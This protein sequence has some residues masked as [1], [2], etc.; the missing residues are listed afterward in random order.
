MKK[1][2]GFTLIEFVAVIVVVAIL[3]TALIVYF[4]K[5]TVQGKAVAERIASDLRYVQNVALT[6]EKS[7]NIVFSSTQYVLSD[8]PPTAASTTV[9]VPYGSLT[10]GTISFDNEGLLTSGKNSVKYTMTDGSGCYTVNVSGNGT[11]QKP[12][13]S[14]SC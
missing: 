1:Q 6:Q 2:Q 3:A 9:R 12:V 7:T 13:Y 8:A 4:P 5:T 14:S 11:V 10:T